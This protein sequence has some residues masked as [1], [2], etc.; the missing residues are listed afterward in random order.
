MDDRAGRPLFS[1][2]VR[3]IDLRAIKN[4]GGGIFNSTTTLQTPFHVIKV[5]IYYPNTTN[6]YIVARLKIC[7]EIATLLFAN[8]SSGCPR[9][10]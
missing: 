8:I 5:G 9:K 2:N 1:D 6:V 3:K 7:C 10:P 4:F